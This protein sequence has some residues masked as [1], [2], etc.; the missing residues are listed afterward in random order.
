[1]APKSTHSLDDYPFAGIGLVVAFAATDDLQHI[2]AERR[3]PLATMPDISPDDAYLVL[4]LRARASLVEAFARGAEGR[5]AQWFDE[6]L[7]VRGELDGARAARLVVDGVWT[8]RDVIEARAADVVTLDGVGDA[9]RVINN[10]ASVESLASGGL[11]DTR[12]VAAVTSRERYV[13]VSRVGVEDLGLGADA[14]EPTYVWTT[15]EGDETHV[16]VALCASEDDTMVALLAP[17][18]LRRCR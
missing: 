5:V 12:G 7:V 4:P 15:R 17:L 16:R 8:A 14:V 13:G 10:L 9:M 2:A 18:S 3:I 6:A 1:V 11:F